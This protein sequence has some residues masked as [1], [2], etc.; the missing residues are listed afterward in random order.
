MKVVEEKFQL[1]LPPSPGRSE[2]VHVSQVIRDLALRMKVLDAKW[3]GNIE[4]SD[5][6]LMQVGIGW[7]DYLAKYQHPEIEFHPG[8]AEK[9]GILMSP[10]GVSLVDDEDY[11]DLIGFDPGFWILHEFKFTRKSSRDFKESLR[12]RAKKCL[13]WLWQ[14]EAYCYALDTLVAKLH[15]MFINGDY[16]REKGHP[17]YKIYRITFTQDELEENWEMLKSHAQTMLREHNGEQ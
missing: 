6:T 4:D 2:G 15:V 12:L 8:E 10:D 16:D 17:E 9:D 11:A 3:A 7:E 13:M 5:T 1:I 14:I